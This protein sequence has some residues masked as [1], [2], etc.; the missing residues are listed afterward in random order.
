MHRTS[1][2]ALAISLLLS[3]SLSACCTKTWDAYPMPVAPNMSCQT[4][5]THGYELYVWSCYEQKRVAI[6]QASA[7]MSCEAPVKETVECGE[8]TPIEVQ[9][10]EELAK[11]CVPVPAGWEWKV[12]K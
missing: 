1:F 2:S 12:S 6:Y 8:L 10:Q 9:L 3:L 7:E 11:G 5:S 4:G